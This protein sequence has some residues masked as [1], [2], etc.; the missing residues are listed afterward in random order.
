MSRTVE[1]MRRTAAAFQDALNEAFECACKFGSGS[2]LTHD[3]M[4]R[5][6]CSVGVFSEPGREQQPL[7]YMGIA[8]PQLARMDVM[9]LLPSAQAQ[10]SSRPASASLS[11]PSSARPSSAKVAKMNEAPSTSMS[12]QLFVDAVVQVCN[13]LLLQLQLH[14]YAVNGDISQHLSLCLN[15][16]LSAALGHHVQPQLPQDDDDS[17]VRSMLSSLQRFPPH[18]VARVMAVLRHGSSDAD[19]SLANLRACALQLPLQPPLDDVTLTKMFEEASGGRDGLTLQQLTIATSTQFKYG[20][21]TAPNIKTLSFLQHNPAAGIA[22]T[23][24]SGATCSRPSYAPKRCPSTLRHS[25]CPP[26][27]LN[28]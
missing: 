5:F 20:C 12:F 2:T 14:V 7:M 25:L 15:S 8:L 9:R 18:L 1:G 26:S 23:R 21:S 28:S 3:A 16:L 6:L 27:T 24:S 22:G 11:R 19:I 10:A 17:G 4:M 13:A